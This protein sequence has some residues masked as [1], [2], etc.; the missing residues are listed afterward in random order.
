MQHA[1]ISYS[2][3]ELNHE[4]MTLLTP[5]HLQHPHHPLYIGFSFVPFCCR[6]TALS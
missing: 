4:H 5:A 2:P 6:V 1:D 3:Y